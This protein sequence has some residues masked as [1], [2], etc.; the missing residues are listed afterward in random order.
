LLLFRAFAIEEWAK[1]GWSWDANC[2]SYSIS[3]P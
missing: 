2:K 1:T 3:I